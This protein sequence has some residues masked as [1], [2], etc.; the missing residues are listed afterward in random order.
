MNKK[1]AKKSLF[2]AWITSSNF[3]YNTVEACPA[4]IFSILA[5]L[6]IFIFWALLMYK[7]Q[8]SHIATLFLQDP[9]LIKLSMWL[10]I[11]NNHTALPASFLFIGLH[12]LNVGI[13][14][15]LARPYLSKL[16]MLW[17]CWYVGIHPSHL[18]WF[19][20]LEFLPHLIECT[21]LLATISIAQAVCRHTNSAL[22]RLGLLSIIGCCWAPI[23]IWLGLAS[24]TLASAYFWHLE[25]TQCSML[26]FSYAAA[27]LCAILTSPSIGTIA[28][29][30]NLRRALVSLF[31]L[32]WIPGS[33]P[34]LRYGF[35]LFWAA[36]LIGLFLHTTKRRQ[37]GLLILAVVTSLLPQIFIKMHASFI[38]TS[39]PA[40]IAALG[41][42]YENT[43]EADVRS[44]IKSL[45]I[46]IYASFLFNVAAILL[47]VL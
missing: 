33:I 7:R 27:Q 43:G 1:T 2:H 19:G 23:N 35:L 10:N 30:T 14:L 32:N 3:F 5:I 12:T 6:P 25:T 36:S 46:P 45:I 24:V 29:L 44:V 17:A 9:I 18:S 20:K 16:M 13:F 28:V 37:A 15:Y 31:G 21:L 22:Y 42:L 38:Y 47:H 39:L 41:I 34:W 40:F 26:F 11:A 8:P 4:P